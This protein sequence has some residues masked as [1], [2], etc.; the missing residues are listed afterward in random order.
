MTEPYAIISK[1]EIEMK[2]ELRLM[3]AFSAKT[4][5]GQALMT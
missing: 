3:Q 5:P 4:A 1:N 2:I